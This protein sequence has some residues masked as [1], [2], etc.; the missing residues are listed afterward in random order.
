MASAGSMDAATIEV[1]GPGTSSYL[2]NQP[3]NSVK[4][5]TSMLILQFQ[6]L[7][8]FAAATKGKNDYS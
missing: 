1:P 3:V 7:L 4:L 8:I 6:L 2:S 5:S